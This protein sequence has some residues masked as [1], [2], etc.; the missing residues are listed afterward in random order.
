MAAVC[1]I[2]ACA[3]GLLAPD[4]AGTSDASCT[5]CKDGGT[6][7]DAHPPS[8]DGSCNTGETKC[9][10]DGGAPMC[11][12]TKSDPNHCGSCTNTCLPTVQSCDAGACVS[13]CGAKT[14]CIPA[15]PDAGVD[16]GD[17]GTTIGPHCA[18]LQNDTNDCGQ[19]G[20][21]CGSSGCA[22]GKCLCSGGTQ[23]FSYTGSM[24]TFVVPCGTSVTITAYG[25][26]GAN[27][28]DKLSTAHA[29]GLGGSATGT[30]TVTPGET[31]YINV[32]GQGSTSGAGGWNGG[33]AG[34]MSTAG[35]GCSGGAAGGGGGM[36]DVR[37]GGTALTNIVLAA[38]G[39]GGSGRDYC[40]GTCQPCG[41]GG[42]SGGG[43]GVTGTAGGAAAA[44]GYGYPGSN[45]NGGPGGTQSAGGAGGT[46]DGTGNAGTAGQQGV[47]GKGGD[48]VYDVAAGG[49]GGGYYG[50]GGGGSAA[51]G[52]GVGGGGGGGGSS[53]TGGATNAS[54]TAGVQSGDGKITITWK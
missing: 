6:T 7:T 50:G 30:I 18:D 54:T 29:G 19:C 46:C 41:C 42:G 9:A 36:S 14:L 28:Q 39:G 22:Q 17:A 35:S 37:V 11:V 25:G 4:D 20:T 1:L 23:T 40:N 51:S 12:D 49:G 2:S 3:T 52:S 43:G 31:L 44:C 21:V 53:Y 16:G 24:Q 33:G 48:G 34:G 10:E 47:G 15:P 8:P 5:T 45:V 32:G 13:T 38:A 26:Q 27:A